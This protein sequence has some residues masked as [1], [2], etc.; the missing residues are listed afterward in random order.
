MKQE[1]RNFIRSLYLPMTFVVLL[2]LI[3]LFETALSIDF[4]KLG[5]HPRKISGLIGIVTAPLIHGDFKHLISN[6]LP[7][8]VLGSGVF[9]FYEKIAVKVIFWIYLLVGLWVWVAARGNYHIGA[10]GLIYGFASF[11]FFS[12]VIRK[13]INLLAISLL[14]IFFYGSMIWGLL[15]FQPEIS[16]ESHLF[17]VIAGGIC[18]VYFRREGH[19]TKRYDWEDEEEDDI[20][21]DRY[22]TYR[23]W[24]GEDE[25]RIR[26]DKDEWN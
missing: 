14:V 24:T 22:W 1:G 9:Y 12:G 21:G 13:N 18:A 26:N 6:T 8:I 25:F 2:W 20:H 5:V 15:P 11:L 19:E 3:K 16:W 10:S 17:G 4:V 7:L 23:N